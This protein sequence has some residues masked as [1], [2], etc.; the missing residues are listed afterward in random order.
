MYTC[1]TPKPQNL[2][3]QNPKT[4]LYKNNG[5]SIVK[6]TLA[7]D[8]GVEIDVNIEVVKD[9][10]DG[11]GVGGGD[12][13]AK[14]E[15]VNEGDVLQVGDNTEVQCSLLFQQPEPSKDLP[16][17]SIHEAP[18]C[19]GADDCSNE[20]EGENRAN[21]AEKVLFLHGIA[22]VEDDWGEEDVEE[23]LWVECSFL[24]NLIVWAISNLGSEKEGDGQKVSH[25][26]T[27]LSLELVEPSFVL[28]LFICAK[29]F[30]C[31]EL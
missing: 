5:N 29:V 18:N 8:K 9:S 24:I 28:K 4:Y 22:C 17:D 15:V 3:L 13:G 27:H 2:P 31:L 14:V 23:N 21:V 10:E 12:E 16:C 30:C 26:N 19:K 20:G 7:K 11:D 1:E 6:Y 25:F